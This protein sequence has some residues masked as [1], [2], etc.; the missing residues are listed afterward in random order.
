MADFLGRFLW[1]EFL[2]ADPAGAQTFYKKVVG[3]GV[4]AWPSPDMKYDLWT[5]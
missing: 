2:A 3:W 1:Y 5:R 4:E